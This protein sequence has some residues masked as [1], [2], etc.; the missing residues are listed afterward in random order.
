MKGV[1]AMRAVYLLALAGCASFEEVRLPTFDAAHALEPTRSE[2]AF[3]DVQ[4]LPRDMPLASPYAQVRGD[5]P[6]G[7]SAFRKSVGL[8]DE[9]SDL[10]IR[11]DFV[12]Y[13]AG[14]IT[15]P[16]N[17]L[18]VSPTFSTGGIYGFAFSSR[19]V[20][21]D[22]ATVT[23]FRLAPVSLGFLADGNWMVTHVD[24]AAAPSGIREGDTVQSIDSAD[25]R[26]RTPRDVPPCLGAVLTRRPR[27]EVDLVWIRP[28]TGRMAGRLTLGEPSPMPADAKPLQIPAWKDR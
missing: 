27:D 16:G 14:G 18:Q 22:G 1:R 4:D 19:P 12:V 10:G 20:L 5:F 28:G 7:Y 17:A 3:F 21:R 11:P 15:S 24:P 6:S 13:H 9:C 25:V 26:G 2:P 23:C 8:L